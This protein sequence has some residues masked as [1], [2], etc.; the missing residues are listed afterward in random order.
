MAAMLESQGRIEAPLAQ[1]TGMPVT[2]P[3]PRPTGFYWIEG[4]DEEPEPARWDGELPAHLAEARRRLQASQ[5]E[6]G[7][8]ERAAELLQQ[9][10]DRLRQVANEKRA[11]LAAVCDPPWT[12]PVASL[13]GRR[14]RGRLF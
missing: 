1:P 7:E 6:L 4:D 12:E 5:Q 3:E 9:N 2:T 11:D 8:A 10:V 13:V 14:W